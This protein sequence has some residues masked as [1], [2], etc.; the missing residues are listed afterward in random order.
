MCYDREGLKAHAV[1]V[2]NQ[3]IQSPFDIGSQDRHSN[4]RQP[5]SRTNL[6][7]LARFGID[8]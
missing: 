2:G 8:D 6:G 4:L 3:F 5:W 7:M 1:L